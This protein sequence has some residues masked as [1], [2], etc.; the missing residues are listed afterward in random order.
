[1]QEMLSDQ[2]DYAGTAYFIDANGTAHCN[3]VGGLSDLVAWQPVP[4]QPGAY[5]NG[6]ETVAMPF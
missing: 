5:T 4:G 2:P 1:M 3:R 6:Q